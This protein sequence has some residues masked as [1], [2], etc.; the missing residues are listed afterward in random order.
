MN[1]ILYICLSRMLRTF[2]RGKSCDRQLSMML[3]DS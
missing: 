1:S 3:M 2:L